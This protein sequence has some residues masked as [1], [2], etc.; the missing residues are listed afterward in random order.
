MTCI[1]MTCTRPLFENISRSINR[2]MGGD[3]RCCDS[4]IYVGCRKHPGSMTGDTIRCV[5]TTGC[6][7]LLWQF[8]DSA[9]SSSIGKAQILFHLSSNS[10]R[11]PSTPA[12]NK[13]EVISTESFL[14]NLNDKQ[15]IK[16]V[17]RKVFQSS[18]TKA[19]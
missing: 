2:E 15:E 13:S 1:P 9:K 18:V 10:R 5:R 16:E 8:I 19:H 4:S 12:R 14:L 17:P 3:E 11:Y 7:I 6:A